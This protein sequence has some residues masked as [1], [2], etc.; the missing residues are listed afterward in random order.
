MNYFN[1]SH[2][3]NQFYCNCSVKIYTTIKIAFRFVS[4]KTFTLY[5]QRLISIHLILMNIE[6]Q[7]TNVMHHGCQSCYHCG[8]LSRL[9]TNPFLS[10]SAKCYYP[11]PKMNTEQLC[12]RSLCKIF[13]LSYTANQYSSAW[14]QN[15]YITPSVVYVNAFI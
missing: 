3:H 10:L 11:L 5:M 8:M 4:W 2:T 9:I 1:I 7:L 12:Y 6:L 13:G 15:N 14:V